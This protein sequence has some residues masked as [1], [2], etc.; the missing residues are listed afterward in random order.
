MLTLQDASTLETTTDSIKELVLEYQHQ[1]HLNQRSRDLIFQLYQDLPSAN[2]QVCRI[3]R[4][5]FR[6]YTVN[7]LDVT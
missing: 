1:I 5:S 4:F 6:K 3:S 2:S 7:C